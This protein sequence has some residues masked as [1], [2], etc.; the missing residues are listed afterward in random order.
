VKILLQLNNTGTHTNGGFV[1]NIGINKGILMTNKEIDPKDLKIEFAP[2]CF[3]N[4]EG[5]QEELDGLIS[6]I[7]EMFKSGKAQELSRSLDFDDLDKEEIE[8]LEKFVEKNDNGRNL[9]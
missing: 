7:T 4:F 1:E 6:E 3:D 2:G 8:I 5:T 9:Q